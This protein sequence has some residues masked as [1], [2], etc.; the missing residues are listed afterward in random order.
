MKTFD[1]ILNCLH[2]IIEKLFL[3]LIVLMICISLYMY[4]DSKQITTLSTFI[5]SHLC[6][7][8]YK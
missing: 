7:L 6:F 3:I 5:K 2:S 4:Y 8:A 1:K